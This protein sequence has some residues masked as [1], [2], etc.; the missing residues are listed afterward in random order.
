L[1]EEQL[2]K[3]KIK[4]HKNSYLPIGI[5]ERRFVPM[6]R[7]YDE[8]PHIYNVITQVSS[9]PNITNKATTFTMIHS[10]TRD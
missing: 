10:Y 3:I 7:H 8:W 4:N 9:H 6:T 5:E 2:K 1:E